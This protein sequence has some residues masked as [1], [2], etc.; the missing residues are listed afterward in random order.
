MSDD[1]GGW[2][3]SFMCNKVLDTPN[4]DAMV[5]RSACLSRF[6]V[7]PLCTP[8]RAN[9][10]TGRFNYQSRVIEIYLSGESP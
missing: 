4:I 2:D 7:S 6:Y 1:Q 8:S 3:Y 5:E 10:M 9:L